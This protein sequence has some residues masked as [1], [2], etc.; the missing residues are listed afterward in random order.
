MAERIYGIWVSGDVNQIYEA[1]GTNIEEWK[2]NRDDKLSPVI[3]S[4]GWY[5]VLST[6]IESLQ[7][8][9]R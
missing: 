9:T 6:T 1:S 3:C 5:R 2:I 7:F 4:S 8:R